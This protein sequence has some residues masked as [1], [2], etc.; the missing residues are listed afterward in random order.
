MKA[1]PNKK[2]FLIGSENT[3]AAD[4][5][6]GDIDDGGWSPAVNPP[7]GSLAEILADLGNRKIL[8]RYAPSVGYDYQY[9]VVFDFSFLSH[10]M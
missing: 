1:P 6:F 5:V 3:P 10:Q 2:I 4:S 8:P 7:S 9:S